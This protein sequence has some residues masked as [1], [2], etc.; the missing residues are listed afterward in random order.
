M[1]GDKDGKWH[2]VSG[3][4]CPVHGWLSEETELKSIPQRVLVKSNNV[5]VKE[6]PVFAEKRP[7]FQKNLELFLSKKLLRPEPQLALIGL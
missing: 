2:M 3:V 1:T 7:F 5:F 6:T 4:H